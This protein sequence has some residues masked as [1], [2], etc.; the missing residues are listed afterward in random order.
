MNVN[1]FAFAAVKWS[2][3]VKLWN[4]VKGLRLQWVAEAYAAFET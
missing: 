3:G 2:L 4:V 1:Q